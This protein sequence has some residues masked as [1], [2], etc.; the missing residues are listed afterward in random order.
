MRFDGIDPGKGGGVAV[1]DTRGFAVLSDVSATAK[2][3]PATER[4]LFDL[5][6][7][8]AHA[9]SDADSTVAVVEK[10]HAMPKNGSVSCFKLGRSFGSILMALTAAQ[11]PFREVPP[12]TWKRAIGVIAPKGSSDTEKKNIAKRKAQQLFPAVKVTH[13]VAD[14]LLI[15]EYAR[16]GEATT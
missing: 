8:I 6:R 9:N 2:K 7:D 12:G 13:A 10:V 5:L 4:D 15:A 1:L 16:R 14:A 3:M 11:I